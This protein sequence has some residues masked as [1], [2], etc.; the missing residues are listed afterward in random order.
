M[1]LFYHN[2]THLQYKSPK[3]KI[4][5]QFTALIQ[6]KR[7]YN[8]FQPEECKGKNNKQRYKHMNEKSLIYSALFIRYKCFSHVLKKKKNKSN[9]KIKTLLHI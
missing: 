8:N 1:F 3:H 7:K 9:I 4:K 6:Y 5:E 2:E